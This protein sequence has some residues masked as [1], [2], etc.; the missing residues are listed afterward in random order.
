MSIERWHLYGLEVPEA[1]HL[2]DVLK[3]D[4]VINIRDLAGPF[5]LRAFETLSSSKQIRCRDGVGDY[6]MSDLVLD[7]ILS[8]TNLP[9]PVD[10]HLEYPFNSVFRFDVFE[11]ETEGPIALWMLLHGAH[12]LADPV[13]PSPYPENYR[14]TPDTISVNATIAA[15]SR[16]KLPVRFLFNTPFA[17]RELTAEVITGDLSSRAVLV[18]LRDENGVQFFNTP[19]PWRMVFAE[20]GNRPVTPS[21]EPVI[22]AGRAFTIELSEMLGE[23]ATVQFN[24]SGALLNAV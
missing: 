10:P 12:K 7:R 3:L 15:G 17:V 6:F 2:G 8:D 24:F 9:C 16:Q 18:Q 22:P 14:E 13:G 19:L 11:P 23:S 4:R 21:P 5:Y 20:R 1:A